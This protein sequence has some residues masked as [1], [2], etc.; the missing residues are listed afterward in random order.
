MCA[1]CKKGGRS[2]NDAALQLFIHTYMPVLYIQYCDEDESLDREG[3]AH[4][5][6]FMREQKHHLNPEYYE[7]GSQCQ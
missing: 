7:E 6:K 3:I 5:R 4:D 1:V 2:R